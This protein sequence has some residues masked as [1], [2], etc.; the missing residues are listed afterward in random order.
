MS[1][2]I[3]KIIVK[4]ELIGQLV[5]LYILVALHGSGARRR[6]VGAMIV[7]VPPESSFSPG[8]H[9]YT[10]FKS[11]TPQKWFKKFHCTKLY[12]DAGSTMAIGLN[13]PSDISMIVHLNRFAT[14]QLNGTICEETHKIFR[15]QLFYDFLRLVVI[16]IE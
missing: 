1:I 6:R 4:F 16:W 2:I 12:R 9:I 7:S 10:K 13:M 14:D 5:L 8:I 3:P 11:C 15:G